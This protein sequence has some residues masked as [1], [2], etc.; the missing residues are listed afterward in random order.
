MYD[1][2]LVLA[3]LT[4]FCARVHVRTTPRDLKHLASAHAVG[5]PRGGL[6]AQVS[7]AGLATAEREDGRKR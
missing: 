6:D 4:E 3:P 1:E 2:V 7:D 5:E